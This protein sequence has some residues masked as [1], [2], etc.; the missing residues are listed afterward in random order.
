MK[1]TNLMTSLDDVATL[2][3]VLA[4]D[5]RLQILCLLADQERSVGDIQNLVGLSQSALSQHLA[6]LRQDNVVKTR[7]DAQSIYY[8][9]DQKI[10]PVVLEHLD[11]MA[12]TLNY[13]QKSAHLRVAE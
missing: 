10:V 11:K 9:L 8:S 7:R 2:L 3:K 5:R 1:Y 13:V 6:R 12:L 4:N